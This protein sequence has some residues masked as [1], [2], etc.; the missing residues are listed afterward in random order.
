MS[1]ETVSHDA[2]III[3]KKK[4][5]AILFII[6]TLVVL[7]VL[8]AFPV[9]L[10]ALSVIKINHEIEGKRRIKERLDKKITDLTLLNTEYQDV[11]DNLK[12][13]PLL[14]PTQGDFSLFVA[15]IEE[16]CKSNYFRL[17]SVNVSQQRGGIKTQ[18]TSYE[19]LNVWDVNVTVVGKRSDLVSLLESFESMPMYPT[20]VSLTFQ[21]E[22]D[23][24]G[25]L[26]FSISMQIYGINKAGIY[27]D[28]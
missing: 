24:N 6:I 7:V 25:F 28:I 3:N 20:V 8:V 1:K 16:I 11:K 12:D 22:V 15:N 23:A 14:F 5:E 19:V 2:I 17:E 27:T 26:K 13:F 10:M 4:K 9:R 18:G 21:N